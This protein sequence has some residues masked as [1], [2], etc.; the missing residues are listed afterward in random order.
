MRTARLA[1]LAVLVLLLSCQGGDEP[2][3]E[4]LDDPIDESRLRE[5]RR[6]RMN[7]TVEVVDVNGTVAVGELR[8]H[9]LGA[10]VMDSC[11]DALQS[12]GTAF[13]STTCSL[14]T[15]YPDA[16]DPIAFLDPS[17]CNLSI[18]HIQATLC[19]ANRLLEL[20]EQ[21]QST[22]LDL[23][24]GGAMTVPPVAA[25]AK[26][27]LTEE[28]LRY[29]R[30]ALIL[31]GE[32][33][34]FAANRTT[35][36]GQCNATE[37]NSGTITLSDSGTQSFA[38]SLGISFGEAY[39]LAH[40]A[41][42][43]AARNNIA[44]ADL[45]FSRN[46]SIGRASKLAWTAPELS[47]ARAAYVLTGQPLDSSG[48][49]CQPNLDPTCETPMGLKYPDGVCPVFSQRPDVQ[50]ALD[51][52]REA[53]PLPLNVYDTGLSNDSLLQ[54]EVNGETQSMQD[55]ISEHWNAP[56]LGS[57]S[58]TSAEFLDHVG[59]SDAD[60]TAARVHLAAEAEAFDLNTDASLPPQQLTPTT[61]GVPR[62]TTATRW[63]A[64][65]LPPTAPPDLHYI[66][67][68][69]AGAERVDDRLNA[70][71][72]STGMGTTD[73]SVAPT[74]EYAERGLAQLLDYGASVAYDAV[75][76]AGL[77][78]VTADL[79]ARTLPDAARQRRGRLETCY[80]WAGGPDVMRI[81]VFGY[82]DPTEI[83]VVAD[84]D[85]LECAVQ[86]TVDGMACVLTDHQHPAVI[87]K[88]AGTLSDGQVGLHDYVEITLNYAP[89]S[90]PRAFVVRSRVAENATGGPGS[91]EALGST[92]LPIMG[93]SSD[94]NYC[95]LTPISVDIG[96][97]AGEALRPSAD[98][99][100]RPD[101]DC[102]G[103]CNTRIPL[104]NELSEDELPFESSWRTYITN[105][106]ESARLADELGEAL[107]GSGEAVDRRAETATEELEA[108]CGPIDLEGFGSPGGSIGSTCA[109][110][111]DCAIGQVCLNLRCIDDA[112]ELARD[113]SDTN[114][115][116]RKLAECLG[117]DSLYPYVALGSRPLCIWHEV[118]N[119]T[120]TC[121]NGPS[122]NLPCPYLA[123]PD[124]SCVTPDPALVGAV[125]VV[126]TSVELG[127]FETD[128]LGLAGD[129]VDGPCDALRA[130]RESGGLIFPSH[131][132]FELTNMQKWARR[133]GWAGR[134]DDYSALTVDGAPWHS[135]G[136]PRAASS[137]G[138]TTWPC[139]QILPG[140]D[141][142]D[143]GGLGSTL[144]PSLF[145]SYAPA[146]ACDSQTTSDHVARAQM[147][148]RM[149]RA[150]LA[151]KIATGV[152]L[153]DMALPYVWQGADSVRLIDASTVR[154][155]DGRQGESATQLKYH[156]DRGTLG[157]DS[158]V[159]DGNVTLTGVGYC[160]QDVSSGLASWTQLDHALNPLTSRSHLASCARSGTPDLPLMFFDGGDWLDGRDPTQA[161]NWIWDGMGGLSAPGGDTP[162]AG[163]IRRALAPGSGEQ[164]LL[165]SNT[166]HIRD[167][168]DYWRR[169][170]P[171]GGF[172]LGAS[173]ATSL[174]E[175]A[176]NFVHVALDG[177]TRR[178]FMDGLELACEVSRN[179]RSGE[180]C[181][182]E[183]LPSVEDLRDVDRAQE[184]LQCA[185][186]N[187]EI[188][189]ER[190]VLPNVPRDAVDA[191]I[192]AAA[193]GGTLAP[194]GTRG[195]AIQRLSGAIQL[196][197][198][199]PRELS[200]HLRGFASDLELMKAELAEAGSTRAQADLS[201]ESAGISTL[202]SCASSILGG[203]PAGYVGWI[204][205]AL[206]CV[207][208]LGAMNLG[209]Q[210]AVLA[211]DSLNARERA[212]FAS[213]GARFSTRATAI[214]S[215][216]DGLR[217]LQTDLRSSL[218]ELE[219]QRQEGQR[220]FSKAL[221]LDTDAA[222]RHFAVNTLTRRRYNT[223]FQRYRDAR[224]RAVRM[225]YLAKLAVEQRLGM[226]M[227]DM[228]EPMSLVDPP[229]SWHTQL[230]T[231]TGFDYERIRDGSDA[232]FESY[233][234]AYIGDYV[235]QLESLIESYRLDY[236]FQDQTDTLVLSLR[237]DILESRVNCETGAHNLL[238][239]AGQL[240]AS[241][242]PDT[243][244]GAR[245][246][247]WERSGCTPLADG[248]VH[249]CIRVERLEDDAFVDMAGEVIF[250][251][252]PVPAYLPELGVVA[253]YRIT[254][255]PGGGD[256]TVTSLESDSALE[257]RVSLAPGTYAMSWYGRPDPM[258][259]SPQFLVQ[260]A[261]DDGQLFPSSTPTRL[262]DPDG[263]GWDRYYFEFTITTS[264][265][266]SVRIIP[267]GSSG[268]VNGSSQWEWTE[269]DVEIGALQ[270]EEI[271]DSTPPSMSTVPPRE[272]IQTTQ[273][274]RSVLP[275][276]EDTEGRQFRST[277]RHACVRLCD[278]GFGPDCPAASAEEHCFWEN[279]FT[280]N[281][282]DFQSGRF[283]AAGFASGNY[284]YRVESLTLN[285]VGSRLRPCDG[286]SLPSTCY[287]GGFL[288]YS[289][290]HVGPYIVRNHRGEQY[291]APLFEG[292]VEH[293]RA[294]A[295]ERYVTN[296]IS[297]A[298]R[299]LLDPYRQDQLAGR[300]LAGR[301]V[302]RVWDSDALDFSALEDLQLVLDYRYWTRLD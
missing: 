232:T 113:E 172:F 59:I 123:E 194:E 292:H 186:T 14:A 141:P 241:I 2:S 112:L 246:P 234:G 58:M 215:L 144:E 259:T 115:S 16:N 95:T 72:V 62:Q 221:L 101:C 97:L 260:V 131:R 197:E 18:C 96:L 54:F 21:P 48:V 6:R 270:L 248:E 268:F 102:T 225:A 189:A 252:R 297:S 253:G 277:W 269:H 284:N 108:I 9:Q 103:L 137:P 220:Q 250:P 219:A 231:A 185:A 42:F 300:P 163:L 282:E 117:D 10:R 86:G 17:G 23:A 94:W 179:V 33:V 80:Q 129:E 257:Q 244:A 50:L 188:Q 32:N 89:G 46:S 155:Y 181:S 146:G 138:S 153:D 262:A 7:I 245:T 75:A 11:L 216:E 222:G 280:L 120:N 135:T 34:R 274:G 38:E 169:M 134:M 60:L 66:T 56:H 159:A 111:G 207:G 170:D 202:G 235:R 67:L 132:F 290:R 20:A 124:G 167:L 136:N 264:A 174:C 227:A 24:S 267:D 52:I 209:A 298:D 90:T 61:P 29:S 37:L 100:G 158:L 47:R 156:D 104:E 44:V 165:D 271:S 191:M 79:V 118:G 84:L 192:D 210:Q 249:N 76:I 85:G 19:T 198:S 183:D 88:V 196:L 293:G 51:L 142:A 8:P 31:S 175:D 255:A 171:P 22:T 105:A 281:D 201:L 254:F 74:P 261:L 110:S 166:N 73:Y 77:P 87:S 240:N 106:A 283:G 251:A 224:D 182:P 184:F 208:G 233:A 5:E 205:G 213:F 143:C 180:G 200:S 239:F 178:D 229:A 40:E 127:I 161:V 126:S 152:P 81:R 92:E 12:A 177:L 160:V 63:A 190:M 65:G 173:C 43:D 199:F 162:Y 236:P 301:Y 30:R 154:Y 82:T 289:I 70:T 4:L 53:A 266:A 116:A 114:P 64:I 226:R 147:N 272:F 36:L 295:A 57:A 93:I 164:V 91:Y 83:D 35:T 294:L 187:L 279:H 265:A 98:F 247:V 109:V 291:G 223:T 263:T 71:Q 237:D 288:N 299:A 168:T 140:I 302:I 1:P 78:A 128:P 121:V 3:L 195:A 256:A 148:Q 157:V 258:S 242:D 217:T 287:S 230:C 286:T 133:V 28:A 13:S 49:P 55:R 211:D 285:A 45:E 151:L 238:A 176:P 204:A 228:R 218:A 149:A 25:E 150:V 69:R 145:C 214:E 276:C 99:C 107:L 130:F 203:T 27:A 122:N 278:G 139:G 26:T 273:A 15:F 193:D 119:P 39:H 243:I 68:A 275:V 212:I 206:D 296:P 41:G 125:T